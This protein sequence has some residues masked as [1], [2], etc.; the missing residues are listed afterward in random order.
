MN[1]SLQLF[2]ME[3]HIGISNLTVKERFITNSVK[4]SVFQQ[5]ATIFAILIKKNRKKKTNDEK[6]L[7]IRI[8]SIS[9]ANIERTLA[10]K[11][12]SNSRK[13]LPKYYYKF[14]PIFDRKKTNQ[15][16]LYQIEI[17]YEILLKI[18]IYNYEQPVF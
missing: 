15:F 7:S 10:F 2:K 8:F 13:K 18:D 14:L 6:R 9:I 16:L 12:N 11:K 17:D 1:V 5:T 4:L 3:I